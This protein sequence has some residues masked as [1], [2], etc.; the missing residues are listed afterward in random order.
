MTDALQLARSVGG[1][2]GQTRYSA[3]GAEVSL[4]MSETAIAA[5]VARVRNEALEQACSLVYGHCESDNVAQR[6]V[7]AIRALKEE[8]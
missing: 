3:T 7:N 4:L 6:T 8:R 2:P 5:L 1:Q